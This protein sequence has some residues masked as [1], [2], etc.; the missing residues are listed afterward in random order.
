MAGEKKCNESVEQLHPN[1]A[2]LTEWA[3]LW[4]TEILTASKRHRLSSVMI[5]TTVG[6][7]ICGV[8]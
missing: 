6:D 2:I 4:N 5:K 3:A 7:E 8:C 1:S